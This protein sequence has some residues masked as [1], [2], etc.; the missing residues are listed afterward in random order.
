MIGDTLL[1]QVAAVTDIAPGLRHLR[2]VAAD[3]GKLP[4][5]AAGAHVQ[6]VL[7]GEARTWRNAYSLVSRP[8]ARD[9]WEIIVRRVPT[10]RGG[11]AFIHEQLKA[12]TGWWLVGR[13]TS[14]RRCASPATT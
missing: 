7:E 9:A 1:L 3:G 10:S 13:A 4:P 6:F 8:G 2:L 11:S 5:A 12:G 14:L